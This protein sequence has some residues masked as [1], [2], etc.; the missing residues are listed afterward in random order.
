MKLDKTRKVSYLLLR[1]F[2]CYSQSLI[3]GRETGK[4]SGHMSPPKFEVFLIVN[5]LPELNIINTLY[6]KPLN[7]EA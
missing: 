5:F 3:S 1:V 6:T 4:Q 2:D 7:L